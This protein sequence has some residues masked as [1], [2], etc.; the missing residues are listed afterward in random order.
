MNS[1]IKG[2]GWLGLSN[3]SYGKHLIQRGF[4]KHDT[5]SIKRREDR[6]FELS[7]GAKLDHETPPLLVTDLLTNEAPVVVLN[8]FSVLDKPLNLTTL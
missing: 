3:N 2:D 6:V 4:I 5:I 8:A 1:E 7:F